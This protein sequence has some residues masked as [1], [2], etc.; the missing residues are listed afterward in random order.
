[1]IKKGNKDVWDKLLPREEDFLSAE[2]RLHVY[3]LKEEYM[4]Y[5][6]HD[7]MLSENINP[8]PV[9]TLEDLYLMI[10]KYTEDTNNLVPQ[11]HCDNPLE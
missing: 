4:E 6:I 11:W 9:R 8:D 3:S 1:M 7:S 5:D 10:E 2:Y